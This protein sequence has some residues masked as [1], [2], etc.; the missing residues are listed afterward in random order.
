MK[1]AIL[2]NNN[3]QITEHEQSFIVD[4]SQIINI[5]NSEMKLQYDSYKNKLYFISKNKKIC[6]FTFLY[7]FK[8][9]NLLITFKN[10]NSNDFSKNNVKIQHKYYNTIKNNYNIIEFIKGHNV[11][12]GKKSMIM[13]NPIWRTKNNNYIITNNERHALLCE[14]GYK[15]IINYEKKN[16]IK[17]TWVISEKKIIQSFRKKINICQIL[18][19]GIGKKYKIKFK[20]NK[21]N[22]YR[23][24]NLIYKECKLLTN[25]IIKEKILNIQQ[26]I[27]YQ[28]IK[29]YDGIKK[30][31]FEYVN[32]YW[33]VIDKNDEKE[34]EFYL[35]HIK[36]NIF[37]K[38]SKKSMDDISK[39]WEQCV[40]IKWIIN[41]QGYITGYIH[42]LKK[43]LSLH[44]VITN[45]YGNGNSKKSLSVDH[46][47]RDKLDNRKSN[48]RIT[49]RTTQSKNT[50]GSIIGTKRN[51]KKNAQQLPK[52]IT[53]EMMP[54]YI[55]YST[56]I[57]KSTDGDYIRE[58]FRIEKHPKLIKKCLSSSK[59]CKISI[60]D[61]LKQIKQK[62]YE[63]DNNII[64][65][66]YK[67][68]KYV[69]IKIKSDTKIC[70][71]YDRKH[72][73]KRYN[74]K[75][76]INNY[77]ESELEYNVNL[78]LEKI[79]EKYYTDI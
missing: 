23:I 66:S 65:E 13:Q 7:G 16:N 71:I 27:K 43:C 25:E 18:L 24:N 53:Q 63:L 34:K 72:N 67:L 62:L 44:Q 32:P 33:L 20:N 74:M 58:F 39:N 54:K 60:L 42:K 38:I 61:K 70:L 19:D 47:N 78:L 5:I 69:S 57:I 11:K 76:T 68:P 40:K 30:N 48:L 31:K 22:D 36:N 35:V 75:K 50:N 29:F 1:L 3:I 2:E 17:I 14:I 15:K 26:K 51:R 55:Y 4:S 46:I 64:D 12:R 52:E 77:K 79:N 37:T 9:N 10:N 73:N 56:E 49:D 28:I 59:S 41:K 21:N 45:Y 6:I 8:K